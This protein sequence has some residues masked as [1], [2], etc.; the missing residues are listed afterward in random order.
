MDPSAND[1]YYDAIQRG[2]LKEVKTIIAQYPD[3]LWWVELRQF[4]ILSKKYDVAHSEDPIEL[5]HS[6]NGRNTGEY[7]AIYVI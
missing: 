3:L 6:V 1:Q 7:S 4:H 5:K 2:R